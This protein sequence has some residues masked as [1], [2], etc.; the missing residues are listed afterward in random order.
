MSDTGVNIGQKFNF[1]FDIS[2]PKQKNNIVV[3]FLSSKEQMKDDF[4]SFP[5]ALKNNLTEVEEIN[6]G[7]IGNLKVTNKSEK[8]KLLILGSEIL[9]GNKLKQNRAVNE[10]VLISENS[11]T[12]LKV[13]CVEKNRWSPVVAKNLSVSESLL[14]SKARTSNAEDIY[15]SKQNNLDQYKLWEKIDEKLEEYNAKSFTSSVEEIYKKRRNNVEEIVQSFQPG[16]NDIGV[17]LGIGS[18]LVSLDVFSSNKMLKVY[19]PRLIRS[20]SLDSFK[21]TNFKTFLKTKDVHKFLRLIEHSNK[22]VYKKSTTGNLGDYLRFNDT[23]VSGSVLTY[24]TQTI[25]FSGFLKEFSTTPEYK[26]KVA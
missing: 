5:E 10:S 6:K 16:D 23:L 1:N 26:S 13:S 17:V 24:K 14:F 18:R 15:S 19:L 25:H 8:Q 11:T 3:F 12:V 2:Q 21:R 7:F 20:V 9:I 4:L 22:R